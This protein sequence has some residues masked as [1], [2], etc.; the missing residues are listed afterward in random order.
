MGG[1]EGRG[2]LRGGD[3][4]TVSTPRAAA[5]AAASSAPPFTVW[6]VLLA[7]SLGAVQLK[8]RRFKVRW[9]T[10]GELLTHARPYRPLSNRL[11]SPC[12]L[13]G[14]TLPPSPCR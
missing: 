2:G 11:R 1:R 3:S 14:E 8:R 13:G 9:M 5:A 12:G 4:P 7:T 10:R 6:R